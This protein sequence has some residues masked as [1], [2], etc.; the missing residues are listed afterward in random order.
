M[1]LNNCYQRCLTN[2]YMYLYSGGPQVLIRT[3]A[4]L[5]MAWYIAIHDHDNRVTQQSCILRDHAR[6]RA[7]LSAFSPLSQAIRC[8]GWQK[9]VKSF[10]FFF[11]TDLFI[12]TAA[13]ICYK[14]FL[15]E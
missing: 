7:R 2:C 9:L 3:S 5:K 12:S 11:F 15:R 14:R 13:H 8:V 1:L 4:L 6:P 10:F